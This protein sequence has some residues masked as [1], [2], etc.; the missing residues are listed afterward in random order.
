MTFELYNKYI[1]AKS[2]P[3]DQLLLSLFISFT[4][5]CDIYNHIFIYVFTFFIFLP[6]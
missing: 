2:L 6:H 1:L 3:L 4:N 5:I